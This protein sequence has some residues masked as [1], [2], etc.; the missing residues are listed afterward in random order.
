M[1]EFMKSDKALDQ[2]INAAT[3]YDQIRQ[4]LENAVER[5]NL[6]VTRDPQTGQFLRREPVT[7]VAQIAEDPKK[8]TRA[9]TIG[10][11]E[12]KFEADSQVGLER[13]IQQAWKVAAETRPAVQP[14]APRRLTQ[15]EIDQRNFDNAEAEMM[16]KRGEITTAE[17]LERTNA[18]ND[19]LASQGFDLQAAASAQN[20]QSWA[21]ATEIFLRDTAEGHSWKGG[22][23]NLELAANLLQSHGLTDAQEKVAALQTIAREM[24]EKGLEFDSDVSQEQMIEATKNAS[25]QE[26]L[27]AFKTAHPDAESANEAFIRT[28]NGGRLYGV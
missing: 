23:K 18:I 6:G 24:R 3:S 11:Q 20:Q 19:Y 12:M 8:F 9:E 16:L 17:F 28:Y 4:L 7:P 27:E 15:T 13:Q 2:D 5:S 14:A 25:P 22:Q 1:T 21:A 26:L 10:G